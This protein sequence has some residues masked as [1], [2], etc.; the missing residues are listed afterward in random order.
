M[1]VIDVDASGRILVPKDL[2]DFAGLSKEIVLSSAV[3][4]LEI[5]DKKNYEQAIDDA[6]GN[7]ADLAEQ[8]MGNDTN[9]E[10]S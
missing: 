2:F 9:H 1:R 10:L 6:T 5:W 3:N 4:I 7:F 8:V